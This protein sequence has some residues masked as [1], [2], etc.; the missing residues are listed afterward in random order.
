[1]AHP[2]VPSMMTCHQCLAI[3]NSSETTIAYYNIVFIAH[4]K[5]YCT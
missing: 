5:I 4:Y 2:A 3:W 1:M